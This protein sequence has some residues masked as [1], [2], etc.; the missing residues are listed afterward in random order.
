[1]IPGR[2]FRRSFRSW[3]VQTSFFDPIG[4]LRA[5]ECGE[6]RAKLLAQAPPLAA[7]SVQ[8]K[9]LAETERRERE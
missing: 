5:S 3:D 2:F 6:H 1:M 4:P 7:E 9:K 8:S